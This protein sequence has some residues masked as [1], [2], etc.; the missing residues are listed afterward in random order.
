MSKVVVENKDDTDDVTRN[1]LILHRM[2]LCSLSTL[3]KITSFVDT[4]KQQDPEDAMGHM[5][6]AAVHSLTLYFIR[7][8][9]Y[10]VNAKKLDSVSRIILMWASFFVVYKS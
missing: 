3:E 9:V 8:Q 1:I 7:T 4:L 10:A 5:S 2:K 6:S